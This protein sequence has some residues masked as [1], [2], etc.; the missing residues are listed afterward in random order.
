MTQSTT[1]S[2][3]ETASQ[4]D[5]RELILS[6]ASRLFA[7]KGIPGTS[8]R[9]VAQECNV[10]A[11]LIYL[12]FKDKNELLDAVSTEGFRRFHEYLSAVD[13]SHDPLH[14]LRAL[15]A[16]Y[17]RFAQEHPDYYD[18]MFLDRKPMEAD[19]NQE[20]WEKGLESHCH[21]HAHVKAC[22]AAGCFAGMDSTVLAHTIWSFIHGLASLSVSC[23]LRMYPEEQRQQ[24]QQ[25]ALDYFN[26]MLTHSPQT[27]EA[28]GN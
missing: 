27:H 17:L 3:Q 16:S 26:Q 10:S 20:A 14:G 28:S 5:K 8:M 24:I 2:K 22:Q 19:H 1:I 23:R 18:L 13:V 7:E 4:T 6:A 9:S 12:Y 21:L 15:G 25:Q 11:G